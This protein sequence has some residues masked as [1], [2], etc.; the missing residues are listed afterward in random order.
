MQKKEGPQQSIRMDSKL[1][2][3]ADRPSEQCSFSKYLDIN[4]LFTKSQL[5]L[6]NYLKNIVFSLAL[7]C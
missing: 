4:F 6:Y 1:A 2:F 5:S 7:N 3:K